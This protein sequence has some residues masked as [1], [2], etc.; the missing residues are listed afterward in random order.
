MAYIT[1]TQLKDRLGLTI[2]A[3]L[4]DRVAGAAADDIVGQ[5]LIDEAEAEIDARLAARF[6]VP[7][8]L[9]HRPELT[10]LFESRALD[11]AEYRAWRGSPF[12]ANLPDR[13]RAAH[14]EASAWFAALARGELDLP[15][16][17]PLAPGTARD[18]SPRIRATPR[19]Y[20]LRE[21]DGL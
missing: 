21:L 16:T 3:R 20:T 18:G 8:S 6:E 4:T 11:L 14:L 1:L 9:A 13:V 12:V 2:Y 17:A 19:A 5:S 10:H 15:A 7:V